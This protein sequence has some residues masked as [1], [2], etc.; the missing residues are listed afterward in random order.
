MSSQILIITSPPKNNIITEISQQAQKFIKKLS[1]KDEIACEHENLSYS[2]EQ[3]CT[4]LKH[5]KKSPFFPIVK[6]NS[7]IHTLD[8]L[9]SQRKFVLPIVYINTQDLRK[10]LESISDLRYISSDQQLKTINVKTTE[11]GK[12]N[13]PYWDGLHENQPLFKA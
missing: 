3:Q 2:Q 7:N 10:S 4:S 8:S 6:Y 13:Q 9:I 5:Y 1:V 11:L 12:L